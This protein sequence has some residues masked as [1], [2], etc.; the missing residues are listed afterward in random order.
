MMQH[1]LQLMRQVE[2]HDVD[3]VRNGFEGDLRLFGVERERASFCAAWNPDHF[4]D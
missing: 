3:I 2:N 4:M 1:E